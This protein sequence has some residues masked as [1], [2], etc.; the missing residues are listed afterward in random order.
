MRAGAGPSVAL[1]GRRRAARELTATLHL[2]LSCVGASPAESAGARDVDLIRASLLND[3]QQLLE[4][5][6]RYLLMDKTGDQPR[7]CWQV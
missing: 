5:L 2:L 1:L 3:V 7:I 6:D 4:T